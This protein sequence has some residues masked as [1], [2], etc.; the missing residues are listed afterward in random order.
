MFVEILTPESTIYVGEVKGIQLPG[1]D[2]LFEILENHA[3]LVAALGK[4]KMKIMVNSTEEKFFEIEG[5]FAQTDKNKTAVLAEGA[6][7]L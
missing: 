1:V 2:G 4:G 6:K 3:P 5:G 7:A